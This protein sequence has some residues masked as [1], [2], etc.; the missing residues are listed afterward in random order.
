MVKVPPNLRRLGTAADSQ[1]QHYILACSAAGAAVLKGPDG[2][3]YVM[4][5]AGERQARLALEAACWRRQLRISWDADDR[6][7]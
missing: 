1:G 5:A 6:H 7:E 4:P 3:A 2:A